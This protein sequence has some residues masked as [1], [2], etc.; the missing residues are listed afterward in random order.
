MKEDAHI[1][2]ISVSHSKFIFTFDVHDILGGHFILYYPIYDSRRYIENEL[3][4]P[5]S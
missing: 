4:V 3:G 5:T 1:S 2:D